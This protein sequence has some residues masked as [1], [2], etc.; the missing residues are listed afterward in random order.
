LENMVLVQSVIDV[1]REGKGL[2][3]FVKWDN[4]LL[5]TLSLHLHPTLVIDHTG[6]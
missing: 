4:I 3:I 2:L 6:V 1:G 5:L